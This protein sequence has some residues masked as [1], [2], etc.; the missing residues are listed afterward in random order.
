[1]DDN[2]GHTKRWDYHLVPLRDIFTRV[3]D[4]GLTLKSAKC[5]IGFKSIAFTGHVEGNVTLQ[6]GVHWLSGRVFDSRPKG[7]R[8][9]PQQR[10]CV[11]SFSNA[12]LSLISTG[13]V[14]EDPY[15]CN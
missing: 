11:V 9:E 10:H 5:L 7:L 3:R 15:R 12:H 4:A 1:M 13:L 8:F 2:L 14:K 6:V